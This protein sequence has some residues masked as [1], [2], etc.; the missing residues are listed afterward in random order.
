M[1]KFTG[2]VSVSLIL[3]AGLSF[4]F[5]GCKK[6]NDEHNESISTEGKSEVIKKVADML[7]KNYVLPETGKE[8][9]DYIE[10]KLQDGAY[11]Q[12]SDIREFA[13]MMTS[14]LQ[15][16]S[17]DRHL[18]AFFDPQRARA[19]LNNPQ[20]DEDEIEELRK[21]NIEKA[22]ESNFG[23][24]KLERLSGN[25]G[26]LVLRFFANTEYAGE[27]AE[28]AM[29]FLA[30]CDAVI[31]DVRRNPGGDASMF[32]LLT[33]YFFDSTPVHLDSVYS[34]I[35]GKTKE[36]WTLAEVK[37]KRM[38]DTDLYI[39]TD[40]WTFSA[41]EAFAYNLKHAGRAHIIGEK[42]AGGAHMV[43]LYP[44]NERLLMYLPIARSIHPVTG[45]NWQGVGVKPHS[46]VPGK[47]TL[48]RAH[49]MAVKQLIKKSTDEKKKKRLEDIL[50]LL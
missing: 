24:E 43:D 3:F 46:E 16:I 34:R 12:V 29:A 50:E 36:F 35:T 8:M 23:F 17:R 20:K 42:T 28:K 21:K 6:V 9:A 11:N 32:T 39:L 31:I 25:V 27:T 33:S 30:Q 4:I 18:V 22:R 19:L 44:V 38:P 2:M 45:S 47:E 1:K 37:G 49:I 13:R 48:H 10:K 40:R 5:Y 41:A 7:T 15:L 14:H 26:Y